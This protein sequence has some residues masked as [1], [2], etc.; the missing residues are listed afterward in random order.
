MF[1]SLNQNMQ[2][3]H[4]SNEIVQQVLS[5]RYILKHL[6]RR[7]ALTLFNVPIVCHFFSIFLQLED[8]NLEFLR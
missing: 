3:R 6:L 1:N 7:K 2:F 8:E 5:L 4:S